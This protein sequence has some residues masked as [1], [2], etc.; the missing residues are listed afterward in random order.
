MVEAARRLHATTADTSATIGPLIYPRAPPATE[1]GRCRP[2]RGDRHL[3]A[4]VPHTFF[5]Q[6]GD[7]S[8][9]GRLGLGGGL[10]DVLSP[11]SSTRI[12]GL[13]PASRSGWG[14]RLM[15]AGVRNTFMP[16]TTALMRR[17]RTARPFTITCARSARAVRKRAEDRWRGQ[18]QF[19]LDL[20]EIYGKTRSTWWSGIAMPSPREGG[21]WA[22]LFWSTVEGS[23]TT[24]R[25]AGG[26][27]VVDVRR[28]DRVMCL[29]Y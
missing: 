23:T 29:H 22:A 28:P 14:L 17:G 21:P 8:G 12:V 9:R 25:R 2:A 27:P 11:R 26:R 24:A 3:N 1:R 4:C 10:I 16:P 5:P 15:G 6:P 18:R 19:G 7:R 20:S 13:R